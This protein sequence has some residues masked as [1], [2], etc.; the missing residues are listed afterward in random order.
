MTVSGTNFGKAAADYGTFRAGFPNSIFRRL[1]EYEVGLPG[2]SVIDLGTGTGTLARGFA[3]RGCSVIGVDPDKRMI[4][5]AKRLDK[6][7]AI[8]I[9]YVETKAEYTGLGGSSA[10]AIAA[11]Q[12]WHW[13]NQAAVSAEVNRLLRPGGKLVV[14]HFDWLPL[15][16]NV[17]E[18]TEELI[19]KYNPDWHLSGGLGM[20]PQW[21]PGLSEAGFRNIETFSYDV[22]VPYT[23]EAWRGRIRASAGVAALDADSARVFDHDHSDMLATRFPASELAIPHRLFAIV[24][25][26]ASN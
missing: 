18:A 24:A 10:D 4:A 16:G 21:L 1:A 8:S 17:V 2:Q 7:I 23:Q 25:V 26:G 20:Y 5:E 12:C 11:G 19:L 6:E 9:E 3:S 13:F 14:A 22:D 15:R